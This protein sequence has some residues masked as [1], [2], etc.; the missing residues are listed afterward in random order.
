MNAPCALVTRYPEILV[1][2]NQ[3]TLAWLVVSSLTLSGCSTLLLLNRE[4][5]AL[6]QFSRYAGAPIDSFTF[7][8]K[9]WGRQ[10]YPDRFTIL[11]NR[12]V[13]AWTGP[14]E[15]YLITVAPPCAAS[16]RIDHVF[17]QSSSDRT[18]TRGT[19]RLQFASIYYEQVP[20]AGTVSG[21]SGGFPASGDTQRGSCLITDI[22]PVNYARMKAD[23]HAS[24]GPVI[25]GWLMAAMPH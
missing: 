23:G 7:Q 24:V 22:R 8:G 11:G 12:Q 16:G 1:T 3:R 21:S 2:R 15:A 20:Y 19:D 4:N 18:V 17:L 13:V 9:P 25:S 5:S 14:E 6:E 10:G